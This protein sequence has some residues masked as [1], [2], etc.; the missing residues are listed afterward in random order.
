MGCLVYVMA[1]FPVGIKVA[2]V[3][4]VLMA[5][6]CPFP[7]IFPGGLV[8]INALQASGQGNL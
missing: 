3:L 1:E 8:M 7:N 2:A 5:G 4:L 6:H